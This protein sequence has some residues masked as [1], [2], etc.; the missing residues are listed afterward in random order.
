MVVNRVSSNAEGI[1]VAEKFRLVCEKFLGQDITILGH[2]INEPL[3]GEGIRRQQAFVQ[4]FPRNQAARNIKY[5]TG[6]LL[7][8]N[9]IMDFPSVN[10]SGGIKG[11]L[12]KF[13]GFLK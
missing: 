5:I 10:K 3:I 13:A 2:I 6:K 9:D 1:M 4:I 7:E 11:F 12:D 8:N